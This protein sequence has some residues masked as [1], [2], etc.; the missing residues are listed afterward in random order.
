MRYLAYCECKN[1]VERRR[2]THLAV[3]W[4]ARFLSDRT[5]QGALGRL[6]IRVLPDVCAALQLYTRCKKCILIPLSL[7]VY[8][9]STELDVYIYTKMGDTKTHNRFSV[10]ILF[11]C[12]PEKVKISVAQSIFLAPLFLSLFTGCITLA[13][14]ELFKAIGYTN[15]SEQGNVFSDTSDS[16]SLLLSLVFST[17]LGVRLFLMADARSKLVLAAGLMP[18]TS[19]KYFANMSTIS[20]VN[21]T[22]DNKKID[23]SIV[24]EQYAAAFLASLYSAASLHGLKTELHLR[25]VLLYL[26][27]FY[28]GVVRAYEIAITTTTVLAAYGDSVTHSFMHFFIV[29]LLFVISHGIDRMYTIDTISP[30]LRVPPSNVYDC[31]NSFLASNNKLSIPSSFRFDDDTKS[32]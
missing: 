6:H 25:W 8:I 20:G 16:I 23:M 24:N 12:I 28:H 27:I 21:H 4:F 14:I 18:D 15:E 17:E 7:C 10:P 13:A 3:S 30:Q 32:Q 11:G 31:F 9:S 2:R 1:A 19:A 29:M 26:T 22:H 5:T